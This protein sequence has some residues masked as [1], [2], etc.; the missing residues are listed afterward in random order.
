MFWK[1]EYIESMGSR[2]NVSGRRSC[3]T[4]DFVISGVEFYY[5]AASGFWP[6]EVL[7]EQA[8][9]PTGRGEVARDGSL[10]A[11]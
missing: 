7:G 2:V 10:F 4:A 8:G 1:Y 9:G 3:L 6:V 5:S 11:W